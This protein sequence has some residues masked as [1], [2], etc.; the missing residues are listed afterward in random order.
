ML[1]ELLNAFENRLKAVNVPDNSDDEVLNIAFSEMNE[2]L[3]YMLASLTTIFSQPSAEELR[4]LEEAQGELLRRKT[5]HGAR[6][7]VWVEREQQ[8]LDERRKKLEERQQELEKMQQISEG[9]AQQELE[10]MLKE[11]D[12]RRKKL[13]ERQQELDEGLKELEERLQQELEERQ[14]ELDEGRKE[15]EKMQQRQRKELEER[16]K[17]LEEMLQELEELQQ[18]LGERDQELE[19]RQQELEERRKELEEML[20]ELEERQQRQRKELEERLQILG[21]RDQELEE[22]RRGFKE[23]ILL[24]LTTRLGIQG[25]VGE[26]AIKQI[27]IREQNLFQVLVVKQYIAIWNDKFNG[28]KPNLIGV[29]HRDIFKYLFTADNFD[30]DDRELLNNIIIELCADRSNLL[31]ED[32]KIDTKAKLSFLCGGLRNNTIRILNF[33]GS[34]INIECIEELTEIILSHTSIIKTIE[35]NSALT[36]SNDEMVVAAKQIINV[37]EEKL[38][39][40]FTHYIRTVLAGELGNNEITELRNLLKLSGDMT[41]YFLKLDNYNIGTIKQLHVIKALLCT[42]NIRMLSLQGNSL[43][44]QEIILKLGEVLD[45]SEVEILY[46][47]GSGIVTSEQLSLLTIALEGKSVRQLFLYKEVPLGEIHIK[48]HHRSYLHGVESGELIR[49]LKINAGISPREEEGYSVD[50]AAGYENSE[51]EEEYSDVD[52]DDH[53]DGA[54]MAVEFQGVLRQALDGPKDMSAGALNMRERIRDALE[55]QLGNATA[56]EIAEVIATYIEFRNDNPNAAEN[57]PNFSSINIDFTSAIGEIFASITPKASKKRLLEAISVAL[58]ES[59]NSSLVLRDLDISESEEQEM[60]ASCLMGT[61][62]VEIQFWSIHSG[63]EAEVISLAH[64]LAPTNLI[65]VNGINSNK[66]FN[67]LLLNIRKEKGINVPAIEENNVANNTEEPAPPLPGNSPSS[68]VHIAPTIQD[69]RQLLQEEIALLQQGL[70]GIAATVKNTNQEVISI[71][72][73]MEDLSAEHRRRMKEIEEDIHQKMQ[74]FDQQIGRNMAQVVENAQSIE[75]IEQRLTQVDEGVKGEAAQKIKELEAD[76]AELRNAL[77]S[78]VEG[79]RGSLDEIAQEVR[80]NK[81]NAARNAQAIDRTN[82]AIGPQFWVYQDVEDLLRKATNNNAKVCLDTF[83][84]HFYQKLYILHLVMANVIESKSL[85]WD[86]E[87]PTPA[88]DM[89]GGISEAVKGGVSLGQALA[90]GIPFVAAGSKLLV[91]GINK[92]KLHRAQNKAGKVLKGLDLGN[93]A[94]VAT[95]LAVTAVD[96]NL[97]FLNQLPEFENAKKEQEKSKNKKDKYQYEPAERFARLLIKKMIQAV[98]DSEYKIT[99]DNVESTLL[100]GLNRFG[101]EEK[102]LFK[103]GNNLRGLHRDKITAHMTAVS[104]IENARKELAKL[105]PSPNNAPLAGV[106]V[107]PLAAAPAGHKGQ[108]A[109]LAAAAAPAAVQQRGGP[110]FGHP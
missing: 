22:R 75:V 46:L 53:N 20:K 25:Q 6:M 99:P 78:D 23:R 91:G 76:I 106:A 50:L 41:D 2:I 89:A 73:G 55:D 67:E 7:K 14:Q 9:R 58:R 49:V 80:T 84:R 72:R 30:P 52:W 16:R 28:T 90:E 109:R 54:F 74:D 21:E 108:G 68:A 5:D 102:G 36:I 77:D 61:N 59:G 18:I 64:R 87:E 71:R 83:V 34:E 43:G 26:D 60:L 48:A 4:S 65:R 51:D 110:Q 62:I 37:F 29:N 24:E 81:D 1:E 69:F 3:C 11:L 93:I 92:V 19:E 103:G 79:M 15:L 27:S 94:E 40:K 88:F 45:Q 42:N 31:L 44:D 97:A 8:E 86:L 98:I 13:E 38:R 82:R 57:M 56:D 63:D 32:I 104:E 101:G 10:E 66:N 95:R 39:I 107:G 100:S 105:T 35:I 33:S 96:A 85:F 70:G 17:K 47:S 12:E